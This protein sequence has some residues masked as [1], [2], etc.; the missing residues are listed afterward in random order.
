MSRS[1][2]SEMASA[3][4]ADLVR[5]ILLVQCAFDSGN[6]NLWNGIGD[7]TVGSVDYVGAGTLLSVGEISE[8]S[9]L[10]ANGLNVA[11][12]GVTEPLISKARD[13]DYQGREL[14]V[15]MGAMDATNSVIADPVIIFSGFMDTMVIND[16]AET[17]TIQVAV[18]NRLIEFE[19]TRVRRYTAE[20]QKIDF[21]ADK[22][23]E[24][25]AEMAEKEIVWGRFSTEGNNRFDGD[26]PTTEP[27]CLV[28]DTQVA[29]PLGSVAVQNIKAG[30]TVLC[31]DGENTVISV[32]AY[33]GRMQEINNINSG[34]ICMTS[35]HLVMTADGWAAVDVVAA[36]HVQDDDI[37]I[38]PLEKGMSLVMADGE[39]VEVTDIFKQYI[40]ATVYTIKVDGDNTYIAN[41]IVTHNK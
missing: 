22:G 1:L 17:A 36:K 8:T 26:P 13:E 12:S 11:L 5:P 23:L 4:T 38:L 2:T 28:A 9:E 19:R 14:T 16:G 6:L 27:N 7:L 20:D 29:T 30:D 15:L 10:A 31:A 34:L 40:P 3:V 21:P 39:P 18:E 33:R 41:G 35:A 24:F 25:V 37:D 32:D